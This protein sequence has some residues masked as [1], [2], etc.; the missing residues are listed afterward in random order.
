VTAPTRTTGRFKAALRAIPA[1]VVLA[2]AACG[3]ASASGSAAP[4]PTSAPATIATPTP[5][6]TPSATPTAAAVDT[7]TMPATVLGLPKTS[8]FN[9]NDLAK[10][11]SEA[12]TIPGG[13]KAA[14]ASYKSTSNRK[15]VLILIGFPVDL[16]YSSRSFQSATYTGIAQALKAKNQKSYPTGA[17]GGLMWCAD[18]PHSANEGICSL[19]DNGGGLVV[20]Y[21]NHTGAQTAAAVLK[22]RPAVEKQ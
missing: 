13:G 18:V 21:F 14:I 3:S 8:E 10:S 20:L 4:D 22:L 9:A 5:T 11:M 15:N 6:P 19:A 2:V 12:I 1:V 16:T 17:M 7:F